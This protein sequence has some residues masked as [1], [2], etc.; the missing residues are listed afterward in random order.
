MTAFNTSCHF[1]TLR[2]LVA[3][4]HSGLAS[5]PPGRFMGSP[6]GSWALQE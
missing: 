5:R 2:S 3:I 1:V 6:P 4:R